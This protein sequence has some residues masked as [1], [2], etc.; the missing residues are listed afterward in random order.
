MTAPLTSAILDHLQRTLNYKVEGQ[1]YELL[2]GQVNG[3]WRWGNG[4]GQPESVSELK[5]VLA[6]DARLRVLVTHGFTDLVTPYYGSQLLLDQLP[7]LGPA[8]RAS[9]KVYPGGHMFY[10]REESRKAFRDD[11][12]R[13]VE[14]ALADRK[15][16]P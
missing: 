5:S 10:S 12:R 4:R 9:L 11:V 1:R 2:N 6:L 14:E 13:H 16:A 3:S 15:P 7:D 8:P